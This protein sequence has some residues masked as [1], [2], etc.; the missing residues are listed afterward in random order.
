MACIGFNLAMFSK[1]VNPFN[2]LLIGINNSLA[3]S[4]PS[5]PENNPIIN[6]SALNTLV[7]SF[8]L[9]PIAR[10]IPISFVLSKTEM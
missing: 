8:F 1:S 2:T 9:A 5:A 4:I 6:V 10:K 7:I 3:I